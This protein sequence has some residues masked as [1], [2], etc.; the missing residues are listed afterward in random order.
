MDGKKPKNVFIGCDHAGYQLKQA[1]KKHLDREDLKV[2]DLGAF[3]EE[4][5][6]YPDITK[7]VVEKVIEYP[8]SFGIMICGTG[9]G[10]AMTANRERGIRAAVCTNEYMAQMA[11]EHNHANM[12]C[13][14]QRVIDEDMALKIVDKFLETKFDMDERHVRR[15]KKIERI[16]VARD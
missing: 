13:L 8:N 12:L 16:N 2:T 14:G 5:V 4:S 3:S 6:D 11:R 10:T 1:I 7:E 9:Q 15:V